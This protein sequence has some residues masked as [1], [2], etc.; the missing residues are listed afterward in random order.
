MTF[1]GVHQLHAFFQCDFSYRCTS[2]DNGHK[3]ASRGPSALAETLMKHC[4][5]CVHRF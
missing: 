2:V 5:V 3:A 4:S 1:S